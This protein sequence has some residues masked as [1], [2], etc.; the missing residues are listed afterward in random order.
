MVLKLFKYTT[1]LLFTILVCTS[2]SGKKDKSYI[3]KWKGRDKG[4]VGY[5]TLTKDRYATFEFGG[6]I[7][8]GTSYNHSGIN[9][10]LKYKINTKKDPHEI[11]FVIWDKKK[12]KEVGRMRGIFRMIDKDKMQ[13]AI[14]FT[15]SNTRPTDF[16]SDSIIF[17][18]IS[19]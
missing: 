4:D 14:N 6:E 11:N 5:L 13:M 18:R 8:G 7:M 17:Y 19:E 1:I 9:A 16:N 15:G 2:F 10:S 3:G 12:A